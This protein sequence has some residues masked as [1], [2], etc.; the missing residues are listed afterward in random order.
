[1]NCYFFCLLTLDSFIPKELVNGNYIRLRLM[2]PWNC[3]LSVGL[4]SPRVR[5]ADWSSR[6]GR[7]EKRNRVSVEP[8]ASDHDYLVSEV[9]YIP[10]LN[11]PGSILRAQHMLIHQIL[12]QP[13]KISLIF[14]P[15]L[16]MR[17]L[18]H[19]EAEKRAQDHMSNKEQDRDLNQSPLSSE[20]CL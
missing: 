14:N 18:K 3:C 4:S 10:Y 2:S 17:K 8:E 16:Q 13:Y 6:P 20:P 5:P 7:R 11:V 9:L 15:F 1:M 12:Q 19:R